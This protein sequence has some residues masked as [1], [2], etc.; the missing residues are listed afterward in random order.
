[1]KLDPQ[2][3]VL[4]GELVLSLYPILVK[5]VS[6]PLF[7]Q[8]LSRF[9]I[10]PALA[11]AFGP[12][13]DFTKIWGSPYESFVA[14]L[15]GFFNLGHVLMSYLSYKLLPAGSAV[16]LFYL[17]PIF[18][19]IIGAVALGE[20]YPPQILLLIP[21][22][23]FGTYLITT[24]ESPYEIEPNRE[25]YNNI[26]YDNILMSQNINEIEKNKEKEKERVKQKE[27]QKKDKLIGISAAILAAITESV[28][29]LF[30]RSNTDAFKSPFYTIDHLYP[31]GLAAL[32]L[33][34]VTNP[35]SK[36]IF[37]T[38]PKN[39]IKLLGFNALFGF[40]GYLARFYGL[41]KVSTL[42]FSILSFVGVLSAYVWGSLFAN[43][44]ITK[45]GLTGGLLI[46][47]SIGLIRYFG[48]A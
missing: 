2:L 30:I 14:I 6:T 25:G 44:K 45:R 13:S 17:Y 47:S 8:M 19:I 38:T 28:I 29:F 3:S 43:E 21:M 26:T 41:P 48:F 4:Y 18:N 36:K 24:A 5:T 22:A 40:T 12:F 33:Y 35:S 27:K 15:H 16:S 32:L 39:W 1:M 20:T 31:A 11:L 23:L 10:F 42:L 46:A 34:G 7:T 9:L 37:D